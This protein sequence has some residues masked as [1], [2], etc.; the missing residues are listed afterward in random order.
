MHYG[1]ALLLL[2]LGAH[3]PQGYGSRCVCVCVCL[4]SHISFLGLLLLHC[5]VLSRQRRS[6]KFVAFSLKPLHCW[7]RAIH[8]L[9]GHTF[10]QPFFLRITRMRI[11]HMQVLQGSR[12][13]LLHAVSSPC[14][15][16]LWWWRVLIRVVY[17][18]IYWF[19]RYISAWTVV[20]LYS[21]LSRTE[22]TWQACE[23]NS[24]LAS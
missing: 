6:K 23:W 15:L 14:V 20:L 10:G 11:V 12:W 17:L 2:T 13:M 7:D 16:A 4:L 3:A 21:W 9:D 22:V 8:P 24:M 5:H 18:A 1:S 19:A